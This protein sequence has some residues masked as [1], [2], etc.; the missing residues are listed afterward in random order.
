MQDTLL[1]S[2]T[3]KG[4][5][6]RLPFAIMKDAVLG[7][8]YELSVVFV[9]KARIKSLNNLYRKK[10]YA[11]DILSF[12][13]SDTSGEIYICKEIS[14]KKSKD[15]DRTETNYL[16]FLFVHGLVHL[17]GYDHGTEMDTLEK[18]FHKKFKI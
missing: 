17:L 8:K 3:T 15:F 10:N 14:D 12:P 13:L 11:T 9:G 7:K 5:L 4:K 2:N 16:A 1:I 6:P 18:K